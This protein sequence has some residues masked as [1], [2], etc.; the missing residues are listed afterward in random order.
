MQKTYQRGYFPYADLA[1]FP[2]VA[3]IAPSGSPG[4]T[5]RNYAEVVGR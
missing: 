2:Q 4:M 5:D 3:N 1:E